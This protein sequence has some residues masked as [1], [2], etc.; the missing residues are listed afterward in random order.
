MNEVEKTE[1]LPMRGLSEKRRV[2]LTQMKN[3][4]M[5]EHKKSITKESHGELSDRKKN[6]KKFQHL[7]RIALVGDLNDR[8]LAR[9]SVCTFFNVFNICA[10]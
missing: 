7:Q 2:R 9:S 8:P 3:M 10:V 6:M 1:L 4:E 5:N